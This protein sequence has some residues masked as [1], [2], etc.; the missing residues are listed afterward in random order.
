MK[1]TWFTSLLLFAITFNSPLDLSAQNVILTTQAEVDAF[2]GTK[3]NGFLLIRGDAIMNL[4]SLST[5]DSVMGSVFIE[6]NRKLKDLDG[7]DSLLYIKKTL[8]IEG[9]TE[10]DSINAFGLVKEIGGPLIL[11]KNLLLEDCCAFYPL[12]QEEVIRGGTFIEN[13]KACKSEKE[14]RE[15]CDSDTDKDGTDDTEDACPNDPNK[16]QPGICGCGV[17]ETDSD[18]DGTPDCKDECPND[19]NKIAE[20][21]C[22]C[23]ETD[24][25]SDNDGVADCEDEC[26]YN[27]D[28]TEVG[29][30]G[31]ENPRIM[32][33]TISNIGG[34]DDR[35]TASL[36]D[37]TYRVDVTVIFE[38]APT[39]GKV[40]LTGHTNAELTF[41][42]GSTAT[43]YTLFDLPF[44]ANG[45]SIEVIA[46]FEG[47]GHCTKRRIYGIRAPQSC[48]TGA[49]DAPIDSAVDAV[50]QPNEALITW[51]YLGAGI[52]Y[53]LDYRPVGAA[54]WATTSVETNRLLINDLTESTTYDYRI[55]SI[56]D[57]QKESDYLTG[58]FTTISKECNLT[59]VTVQNV[60]CQDNQT[61][62]DASDDYLTFDLIVTGTN[63][64]NG[65]TVDSVMGDSSGQ[66]NIVN[67]YSTAMGTF[68]TDGTLLVIRDNSDSTCQLETILI[69]PE[70]CDDDCQ[71]SDMSLGEI[72]SC[73]EG[74]RF[75]LN[76]D[77]VIADVIVNFK[78]VPESGHLRLEAGRFFQS[79]NVSRL[80]GKNSYVFNRI[81]V[82]TTG[83][84]FSFKAI[85]SK[86]KS[87]VYTGEFAGL[88]IEADKLCGDDS[89]IG[90]TVTTPLNSTTT[91]A[92]YPNPANETLFL[93]Y[94]SITATP[95]IEIFDL[96]GQRVMHQVIDRKELNIGRLEKGLYHLVIRDGQQIQTKKFI[97][98]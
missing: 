45:R 53:E 36:L 56:C 19:P 30:C 77:F 34:C 29:I 58:Q 37:D 25:D 49:C 87:C 67:S 61:P 6:Y 80:A 7:L 11:R 73:H 64:G 39:S 96:L 17:A 97:K 75:T 98:N 9:N 57:G 91:F 82:P 10:L 46:T 83:K 93:N 90:L 51:T 72:H 76:D 40:L 38:Q 81:I 55:R 18:N 78:N 52:T 60:N 22:G 13:N 66:Y 79:V 31:C 89:R 85:F 24:K 21:N 62:D 35:G 92:I 16:T 94:Q 12:L 3:I 54:N 1:W 15:N 14:L 59:G 26:P 23:G 95:I 28:I 84:D 44:A 42:S 33:I 5:L 8:L 50:N 27:A 86:E 63:V 48:S 68:G 69:G 2:T 20:G 65:F 70:S 32:D 41:S 71:I 4:H 74:S 88:T 43:S 47:N